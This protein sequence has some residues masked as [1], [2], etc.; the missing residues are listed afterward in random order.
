[1]TD[2]VF[3]SLI[4]TRLTDQYNTFLPFLY[5][6]ALELSAKTAYFI[7]NIVNLKYGID[8]TPAYISVISLHYDHFNPHYLNLLSFCRNI[9]SNSELNKRLKNK[10]MKA[11]QSVNGIEIFIDNFLAGQND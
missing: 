9:W 4:T 5:A 3:Y 11:L 2:D 10:I 1:M 8:K 7:D 6:H